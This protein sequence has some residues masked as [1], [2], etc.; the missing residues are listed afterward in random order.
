MQCPEG[1]SEGRR[2]EISVQL[3]LEQHTSFVF[4]CPKVTWPSTQLVPAPPPG[5]NSR[6]HR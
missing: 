4:A 5:V 1:V 3:L 6:V 2:A